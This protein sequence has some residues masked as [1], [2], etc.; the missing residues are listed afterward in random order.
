VGEHA[1]TATALRKVEKTL[2]PLFAT[3]ERKPE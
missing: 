2:R 1:E 3:A